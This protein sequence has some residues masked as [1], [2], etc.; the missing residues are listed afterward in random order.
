MDPVLAP[1]AA[2]PALRPRT[3]LVAGA[4]GRLGEAMLARALAGGEYA[5]VVALA[6]APM[7]LGIARLALATLEAL[8]PLDDVF[9]LLS[10]AGVPGTRSFHGRD[11]PFVQVDRDN[12][13]VVAR[14]A[15]AAGATRLLLVAPMP[16]WQHVGALHRGLGG[17][18]ELELARLPFARLTVLRPVR[19]SGRRAAGF[20]ER[21]A[22]VYVSLQLLML[23]RSIDALTSEQIA[24]CALAAMR[25]PGEGVNVVGADGMRTLLD[26][27]K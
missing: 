20:V 9:V 3:A 11:A 13:L 25:Q 23:P 27:P 6:D 4:V 12:A 7:T 19:E 14:A 2:A 26:A 21:V 16:A 5:Q 22:S 1:T 17:P 18:L 24:R 15:Q 10:E 8:P